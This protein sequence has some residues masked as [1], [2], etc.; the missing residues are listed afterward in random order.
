MLHKNVSLMPHLRET[1]DKISGLGRITALKGGIV[2][3]HTLQFISDFSSRDSSTWSAGSF[4]FGPKVRL[5]VHYTVAERSCS[6]HGGQ[7]AK[8]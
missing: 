1:F 2:V 6:S 5:A 7:E 8:G 4:A 3:V